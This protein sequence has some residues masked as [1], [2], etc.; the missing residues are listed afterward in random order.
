MYLVFFVTTGSSEQLQILGAFDVACF[1][2]A[3][4]VTMETSSGQLPFVA[5]FD[6]N[7]TCSQAEGSSAFVSMRSPT[8][9]EMKTGLDLFSDTA[10]QIPLRFLAEDFTM[11]FYVPEECTR[12]LTATLDHVTSTTNTNIRLSHKHAGFVK[13]FISGRIPD[14]YSAHLKLIWCV[15]SDKQKLTG[16]EAAIENTIAQ[17]TAMQEQ[18]QQTMAD[19]QQ[20]D[21]QNCQLLKPKRRRTSEHQSAFSIS[22]R[23]T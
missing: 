17:L 14:V 20:K 4:A 22:I 16:V 1:C 11:W 23:K 18:H 3:P 10:M 7:R 19:P 6:D 13:L 21:L 8:V 2:L 5:A 12:L 9:V 15:Q